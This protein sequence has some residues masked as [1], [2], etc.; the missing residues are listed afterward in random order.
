VSW[1]SAAA[2][3][4]KRKLDPRYEDWRSRALLA[5]LI[6]LGPLL[7]SYERYKWR[8]RGLADVEPIR[9]AEP[10]QRPEGWLAYEFRLGYWSDRGM[11]K[12]GLLQALMEFLLP[13]KYLIDVDRGWSDWDIEVYRGAWSRAEIAVAVENHGGNRRFLRVRCRQR[14]SGVAKLTLGACALLLLAGIVFAVPE[15]VDFAV[16]LGLSTL[17]LLLYKSYRLGQVLHHVMEIVAQQMQLVSSGK[18]VA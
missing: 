16:G 9:F 7:R 12:E 11:E 3:A 6:Y 14:T 15:M 18:K 4:S 17:A 5:L 10:R 2:L 1:A 8:L 13:R